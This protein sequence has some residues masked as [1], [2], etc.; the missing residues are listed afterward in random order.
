MD[1]E[2]L[3]RFT[4][5]KELT[6]NVKIMNKQKRVT[7]EDV[8]TELEEGE[9][10]MQRESSGLCAKYITHVVL[11]KIDVVYEYSDKALWNAILSHLDQEANAEEA[12]PVGLVEPEEIE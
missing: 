1:S 7:P 9:E 10:E 11:R 12:K 3:K 5:G 6:Y 2:I 8:R 4:E